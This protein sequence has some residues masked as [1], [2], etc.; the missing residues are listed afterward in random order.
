M[1]LGLNIATDFNNVLSNFNWTSP[2]WDMFIFLLFIVVFLVYCF[3]LRKKK[4]VILTLSLYM[5]LLVSQ[6]VPLF[7]DSWQNLQLGTFWVLFIFIFIFLYKSK[8]V[9]I[10]GGSMR[11]WQVILFNFFHVGLLL[12]INVRLLPL[13]SVRE[14]MPLSQ[15]FFANDWAGFVWAL[16]PILLMPFIRNKES[17]E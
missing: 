7:R 6:S 2:S 9:R 5:A 8:L 13:D 12:S 1:I 10:S 15:G 14:M 17:E 11:W 16:A 3:T 4:I